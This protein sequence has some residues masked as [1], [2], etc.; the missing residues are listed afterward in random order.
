MNPFKID[1]ETMVEK[2]TFI[3]KKNSTQFSNHQWPIFIELEELH[4]KLLSS[5]EKSSS[6]AA[7]AGDGVLFEGPEAEGQPLD[8]PV[9]SLE[10]S[11]I[12]IRDLTV[13]QFPGDG[14]AIR[15]QWKSQRAMYGITWSGGP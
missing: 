10:A 1:F 4:L 6:S 13:N 8:D 5:S 2:W 14:E 9:V 11:F 12:N 15:I 3:L 7:V